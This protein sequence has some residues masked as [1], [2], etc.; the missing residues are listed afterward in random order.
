[1]THSSTP[2]EGWYDDPRGAGLRWWDGGRWTEHVLDRN[3]VPSVP[4]RVVTAD[5]HEWRGEPGSWRD[6]LPPASSGAGISPPPYRNPTP[7]DAWNGAMTGGRWLILGAALL[8][9]ALLPITLIA[10]LTGAS[11]EAAMEIAAKVVVYGG[12]GLGVV[13]YFFLRK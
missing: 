13:W 1:M 8:V 10:T 7:M 12:A 9:F 3:Q 4:P 6:D 5:S 2:P 11:E